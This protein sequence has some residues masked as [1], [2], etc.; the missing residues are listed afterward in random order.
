M[1][2]HS[3]RNAWPMTLATLSCLTLAACSTGQSD[4][5]WKLIQQQQEKQTLVRQHEADTARKN[6]PG[7]PE[8]LMAMIRETQEQQRYFASLAYIDAYTKQFGRNVNLDAARANALRMTGQAEQSRVAYQALLDTPQAAEGWHG[9]GLLAASNANYSQATTHLATAAALRPT[10][11]QILNDLGYARLHAGDL[12]NARLPLG[13]A[14][15]LDPGNAKVL[16]NLALLLL[17]EGNSTQAQALM[18]Q[19]QMP[20]ATR[21]QVY[22][23]TSELRAGTM[24]ASSISTQAPNGESAEQSLFEPMTSPYG[25]T[26]LLR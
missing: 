13:Q 21:Q 24:A 26:P 23:L 2:Q 18:D 4:T 25:H 20:E 8:V 12:A 16:A 19:A 1:R 6:T 3:P 9:L 10:D 14:A 11:V 17:L 7:E 15:E 22:R 5:A